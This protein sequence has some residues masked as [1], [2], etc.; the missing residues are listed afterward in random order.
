M[1]RNP[2]LALALCLCAILVTA[3]LAASVPLPEPSPSPGSGESLPAD[4]PDPPERTPQ[5]SDGAPGGSLLRSLFLG[6]LVL[7]LAVAGVVL[8]RVVRPASPSVPPGDPTGDD[9]D[10]DA[11]DQPLAAVAQAAGRAADRLEQPST[12]TNEVYRAWEEMSRY[13]TVTDRR[14]TTPG[15]FAAAAIRAGMDEGDVQELTRLFE[16]VRYGGKPLTDEDERRAIALLRHI[17]ATYGADQ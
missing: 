5:P 10:R 2:G 4:P 13:V 16:A 17:E 6:G 8:Y 9:D 15:E 11:D 14:S 1:R 3:L 12:P 7:V